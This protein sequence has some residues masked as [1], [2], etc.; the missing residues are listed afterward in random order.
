MGFQD[1]HVSYYEAPNNYFSLQNPNRFT[2]FYG[3]CN[4]TQ[5]EAVALARSAIRR[6]GYPLED[7]LADLEPLVPPL[8]HVGTN[9]IPHYRI[10]W[11]D[12]R[13]GGTA[14]EIDVDARDSRLERISFNNIVALRRPDPKVTVQP[15]PLPP[16]HPWRK[17]NELANG[18]NHEYAY[19]LAPVVFRAV[20]DWAHKLNLD[21][22][23]PVTTNEVSRFYCSNNGGVPYVELTIKS[24]WYFVYRVNSITYS[25]S[26]HC[27]FESALLPFRVKDYIGKARLTDEQAIEFARQT[28]AKLGYPPGFARTGE[29]P[30]IQRPLEIKGM[31]SIPRLCVEWIYPN[32]EKPHEQWIQVEVDCAKGTAEMV[33]FDDVRL[34]DKAPDLGIP[35]DPPVGTNAVPQKRMLIPPAPSIAPP[36]VETVRPHARGIPDFGVEAPP[37]TARTMDSFQGVNVGMPIKDLINLCGLPDGDWG[38][39]EHSLIW[40]LNDGSWVMIEAKDLT[41]VESVSHQHPVKQR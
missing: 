27:F 8:E 5:Q 29:K 32:P 4:M 30:R 18:I 36:P 3:P 9:V 16:D 23:L 41:C 20:E 13:G 26:P 1:G 40:D 15:A 7:V 38:F 6:L 17:M 14:T 34:W 22:P 21:L 10:R 12:P 35:I 19:R 39:E 25:R 2:E 24:D 28:V 11:L 31:S 37:P 33:R